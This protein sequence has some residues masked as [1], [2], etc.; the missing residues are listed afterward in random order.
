MRGLY[1]L[2]RRGGWL[3]KPE[4]SAVLISLESV[5]GLGRFSGELENSVREIQRGERGRVPERR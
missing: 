2:R 5:G 3:R 4:I 1:F